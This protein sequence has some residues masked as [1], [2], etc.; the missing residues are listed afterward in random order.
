MVLEYPLDV[1]GQIDGVAW[2]ADER[3]I[4]LWKILPGA[5][6]VWNA[7]ITEWIEIGRTRTY[8]ELSA[9][10]RVRYFLPPL[11]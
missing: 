7:D 11:P 8:R 5:T 9:E 3:R 2:N 6:Y 1:E 4:L 10:E